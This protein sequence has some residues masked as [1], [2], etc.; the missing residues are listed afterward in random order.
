MRLVEHLHVVEI[1]REAEEDRQRGLANGQEA[2]VPLPSV[3]A[4]LNLGS[5]GLVSTALAHDAVELDVQA[6]VAGIEWMP[7]SRVHKG[8]GRSSFVPCPALGYRFA[9]TL[10]DL[11][12][13]VAHQ[14]T[15]FFSKKAC[16]SPTSRT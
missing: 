8:T 15:Q 4:D 7:G 2:A 1:L 5:N 16:T 12:V 10:R 9:P 13:F 11:I 6:P 14:F 3:K